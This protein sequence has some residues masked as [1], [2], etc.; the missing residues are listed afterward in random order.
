[1]RLFAFEK[2]F[3]VV[4]VGRKGMVIVKCLFNKK[5]AACLIDLI[6]YLFNK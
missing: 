3:F 1:M 2:D 5:R 4:V 6:E